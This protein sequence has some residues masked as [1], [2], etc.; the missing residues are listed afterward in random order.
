MAR[1]VLHL[2]V[3]SDVNQQRNI[4]RKVNTV[5]FCSGTG[6][7]SP[8]VT[9]WWVLMVLGAYWGA[10]LGQIEGGTLCILGDEAYGGGLPS[11]C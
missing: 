7:G 1:L 2:S 3:A 9:V 5:P 4:S 6:R 11:P 10:Y 8:G